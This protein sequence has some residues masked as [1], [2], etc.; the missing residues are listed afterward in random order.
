MFSECIEEAIHPATWAVIGYHNTE[1]GQEVGHR[2]TAFAVTQDGTLVTCWHV[3]FRD[4]EEGID[5]DKIEVLQPEIAVDTRYEVD[6]IARD[7]TRDSAA[8]QIRDDTIETT[9]VR[10]HEAEQ[11]VGYGTSCAMFGHPLAAATPNGLRIF[12][13]ASGGLLSMPYRTPRF[14]GCAPIRLYELDF[15]THGGSSGG[16]V[17]LPD[18]TVFAMVSG[19]RLIARGGDQDPRRSNLSIAIDVREISEFLES[20]GIDL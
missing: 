4:A 6:L 11:P 13:R 5:L 10:L 14:E 7:K 3:T 16:P 9:P 20:L 19:S 12:T 18:G 1:Q 15:F 17:F 2:G 8:L